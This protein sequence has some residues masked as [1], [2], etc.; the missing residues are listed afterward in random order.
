MPSPM[1]RP[2]CRAHSDGIDPHA[3]RCARDE[4][5]LSRPVCDCAV[6][7]PSGLPAPERQT[8]AAR[9]RGRTANS[10]RNR[11]FAECTRARHCPIPNRRIGVASVASLTDGGLALVGEPSLLIGAVAQM[12]LIELSPSSYSRMKFRPICE[13]KLFHLGPGPA[14][15]RRAE[16]S[17]VPGRESVLLSTIRKSANSMAAWGCGALRA[18]ATPVS[19][20][21]TGRARTSRAARLFSALA[22]NMRIIDG[23]RQRGPRPPTSGWPGRAP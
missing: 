6:P 10:N 19:V 12:C 5:K 16:Y 18:M 7:R 17:R 9:R 11:G 1:P 8:A 2:N 22:A 20:T 14:T 13:V 4:T 23:R 15:S 3:L 21:G